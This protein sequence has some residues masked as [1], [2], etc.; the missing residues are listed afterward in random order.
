MIQMALGEEE[1]TNKIAGEPK[2]DKKWWYPD[3][4]GFQFDTKPCN[5]AY[6]RGGENLGSDEKYYGAGYVSLPWNNPQKCSYF[7]N[8]ENNTTQYNGW[9]N[10]VHKFQPDARFAAISD[11]NAY[12][13]QFPE[14]MTPWKFTE[15]IFQGINSGYS[16]VEPPL[17]DPATLKVINHVENPIDFVNGVNAFRRKVGKLKGTGYRKSNIEYGYYYQCKYNK[18]SNIEDI[19]KRKQKL[20]P[21]RKQFETNHEIRA[22]TGD[23][24]TGLIV[25]G[26]K[27]PPWFD[28][29]A[30]TGYNSSFV[31]TNEIC[32]ARINYNYKPSNR[33]YIN[34][35]LPHVY[36]DEFDETKTVESNYV[37]SGVRLYRKDIY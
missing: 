25:N 29:E 26:I 15:Y 9:L 36:Q 12:L 20:G 31:R 13:N 16:V 23:L 3:K 32:G 22:K 18:N 17:Y 21:K 4:T 6:G 37:Y 1:T 30:F 27:Y 28:P 2:N 11:K 8:T 10:W 19:K 33:G 34:T 7:D 5:V 35:K 24:E 14:I